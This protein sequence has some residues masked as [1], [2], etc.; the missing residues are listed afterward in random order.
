MLTMDLPEPYGYGRIVRDNGGRIQ[1]IV[2]E[3]DASGPERAITRSQQ[4][5]LLLRLWSRCSSSLHQLAT[6]N[7]QGEYYLTDLVAAVPAAEAAGWK[8]WPSNRRPSCA[9]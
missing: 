1:R 4:R 6:D 7:A 3:R 9:A 8:R 2:E 5:H